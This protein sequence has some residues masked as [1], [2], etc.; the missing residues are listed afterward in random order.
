MAPE[1]IRL[2]VEQV[3]GLSRYNKSFKVFWAFVQES[4]LN[5]WEL[6]T[7]DIAAQ[8]LKMARLNK[9]EA[10]NA[11]SALLLF[12]EVQQLRFHPLLRETKRDWNSSQV[13]YADFWPA[14]VVLDKLQSTPLQ[15]NDI[16][17]VRD[18]FILCSRLLQLSR[19]VDLARTWR[20]MSQMTG[21][22]R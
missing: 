1:I 16:Q 2:H 21:G 5:P 18:R 10:R 11:Y 13:M 14:E 6:K 22:G 9:H 20:C 8:L 4:G 12:P 7:S 15:W 17:S 3:Q 19:S